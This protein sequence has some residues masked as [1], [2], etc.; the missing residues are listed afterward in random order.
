[1]PL[2]LSFFPEEK[3]IDHAT[4][5]GSYHVR[6]NIIQLKEA[7][8][9]DQLQALHTHAGGC[10][11]GGAAE[12]IPHAA[13]SQAAYKTIGD[14]KQHVLYHKGIVAA[15]DAPGGKQL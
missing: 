1:M 14:K 2:I 6:Q 11:K 8:P 3:Q 4:Q 9:G 13:K 12:Y 7:S 15:I 5:H 10:P